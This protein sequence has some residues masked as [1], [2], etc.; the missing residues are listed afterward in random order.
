MACG[1]LSRRRQLSNPVSL[2][3]KWQEAPATP[4]ELCL[5]RAPQTGFWGTHRHTHARTFTNS[6][7]HT[8]SQTHTHISLP[9]S[10]SSKGSGESGAPLG[11]RQRAPPHLPP[12]HCCPRWKWLRLWGSHRG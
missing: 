4:S 11:M 9:Y 12:M 8:F 1:F 5:P 2:T 7:A 10:F 3:R 6:D